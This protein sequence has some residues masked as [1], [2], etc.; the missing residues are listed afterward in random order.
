M[1]FF[2][3]LINTLTSK[4]RVERHFSYLIC[5]AFLISSICSFSAPLNWGSHICS[6]WSI[7]ILFLIYGVYKLNSEFPEFR[8]FVEVIKFII[9]TLLMF[10]IVIFY[11]GVNVIQKLRYDKDN[12]ILWDPVL[13]RYDTYLLGTIFPKG[14][15]SL[16]LDQDQNYGV[17]TELGHIYSELFQ[18]FYFTYYFWGNCLGVWLTYK[19]YSETDKLKK[20][21]CYRLILMF[22]TSW[23]SGILLNLAINL[24]VPAVS[25]R[26]Y[27]NYEHEIHGFFLCDMIRTLL[28]NGSVN[29]FGA[30]PSMHSNLSWLVMILSYQ[31]NL[32]YFKH[33]SLVVAVL[34]TIATL[35]MRYHYFV[36]FIAGFILA[37]IVA[38][39]GGFI[40]G[41][42]NKSLE[43][44]EK[45]FSFEVESGLCKV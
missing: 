45:E 33:V 43:L 34:I 4:D 27:L 26:I 40:G 9:F 44:Y 37:F 3:Y 5:L 29:T 39:F 22:L 24:I 30:F 35:I 13:V 42:F 25:P 21:M 36:D 17:N 18:F 2:Q 38:W 11:I 41:M 12:S 31:I 8:V 6:F 15:I 19:Y 14:Q 23:V 32:K 20:R 1:S 10:T 16:Y 28:T 7:L